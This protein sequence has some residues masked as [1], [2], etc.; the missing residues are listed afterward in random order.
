MKYVAI[1]FLFISGVYLLLSALFPSPSGRIRAAVARYGKTAGIRK[2]AAF[3]LTIP[4]EKLSSF[5]TP[6][7]RL[8][9]LRRVRLEKA[10]RDAGNPK[11]AEEF[12]AAVTSGC[13]IFASAGLAFI[14]VSP[15]IAAVL[16]GMSVYYTASSFRDMF[17]SGREKSR[18]IE[19]ELPRFASY[20]RNSLKNNKNAL[21]LLERYIT[22]NSAFAA[23]LSLTI[24]DIKT[25]SFETA[26][27]RMNSRFNSEHLSMIIRGLIGIYNGDDVRY[28]FDLLEKDFTEIEINRL[29]REVRKIPGKMRKSM[30]IVYAA[31]AMI[32]FTPILILIIDNLRLFFA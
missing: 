31:I 20:I 27:L 1:Y 24:A 11:S 25:S 21:L 8:S 18:A 13:L 6:F 30:A 12:V 29:R 22:D 28:Y 7:V 32:F 17:K 10:L 2:N 26:L 5:L 4:L 15:I 9:K 3:R 14:P 16:F 19:L 23:E